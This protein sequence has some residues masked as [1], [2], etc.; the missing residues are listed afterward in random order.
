MDDRFHHSQHGNRSR[1]KKTASSRSTIRR[2]HISK[3]IPTVSPKCLKPT[4]TAEYEKSI[5]HRFYPSLI[6]TV[7]CPHLPDNTKTGKRAFGH[8]NRPV[9]DWFRA[10]TDGYR[11]SRPQPIYSKAARSKKGVRTI[12][13]PGNP[14]DISGGL[15]KKGYFKNACL[16]R[17][18]VISAPTCGAV[19]WRG[20]MGNTGAAGERAVSTHKPQLCRPHGPCGKRSVPCKP[21]CRRGK[22]YTGKNRS[23]G[24]TG[25]RR[26]AMLLK[27]KCIQIRG[28]TSIPTS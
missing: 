12:I 17:G 19:P 11:T 8:R 24:R 18:C 5:R 25:L 6:Y 22:R 4:R 23:P 10:R 9:G 27:G 14:E 21:G 16:R 15:W 20:T 26:Y 3:S 13:F 2:S 7:S 28:T 1:R